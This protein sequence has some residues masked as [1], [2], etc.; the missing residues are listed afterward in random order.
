MTSPVILPVL[1]YVLICNREENIMFQTQPLLNAKGL[2][3]AVVATLLT[4]QALAETAGR[5]TF[6]PFCY[7]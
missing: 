3:A 2:L 7:Q 1:T 5:V 4:G 6:V